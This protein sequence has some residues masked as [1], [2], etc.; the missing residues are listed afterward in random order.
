M[1]QTMDRRAQA[2]AGILD[3]DAPAV[4]VAE[5]RPGR[6]AAARGRVDASAAQSAD[7]A[8]GGPRPGEGGALLAFTHARAKRYTAQ[9]ACA[10]C[11]GAA[12]VI[13]VSGAGVPGADLVSAP[14]HLNLGGRPPG[15]GGLPGGLRWRA[16]EFPPLLG[17]E[18][19][20]A[21]EGQ[22]LPSVIAL[23]MPARSGDMRPASPR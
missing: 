10:L 17:S 5:R 20:A 3:D 22:H 12:E 8:A 11:R 7:A 21:T 2:L 18:P 4:A 19:G 6:R 9:A 14:N 15:R 23:L 1:R 13:Q 16:G